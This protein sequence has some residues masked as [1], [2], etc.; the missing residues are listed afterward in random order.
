[1]S[2]DAFS[3]VAILVIGMAVGALVGWLAS[4]PA[5]ARLSGELE[6]ERASIAERAR[7]SEQA[8]AR[9]RETFQALSAEA[10]R[11][12]NHAFLDLAETR[13]REA[14]SEA[15]ADLDARKQA[16]ENLLTPLARTL[17]R[18]DHE[19]RESERRRVEAATTLVERITALDAV[20]Q[21]LRRETVR[22]VDALKRPG[23]RG[24]WGE[25][26]L[27][28]VVE[29]AGMLQ[30]CDFDAQTTV[31]SSDADRRMRPDVI[32]HLAGGKHL[33]ID[34]KAPLDAYLKALDAPDESSRQAWLA[35]HAQQ[36]RTHLLQLAAKGYAA[37]VHPS[38]DFV[39][40][41][42][43]GEM[44]FS[45]ALEQDAS[46]IE[47]G[48]EQRVIPASPTT[49]I[50]LLRAVAYG[51]QQEAME[52]NARKIG[53]LG[54][55]LYE[56]VRVLGGHFDSLGTKLKG[57]LDAYNLAVGSLERNVLVKAR[58]LKELHAANGGEE[59]MT[60]ESIDQVPRM[61]QAAELTGGLPF[62]DTELRDV[63]ENVETGDLKSEVEV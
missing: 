19:I 11:T 24:R 47:F 29:M 62:Q 57:A 35:D 55:N 26:Q 8:D 56:S 7:F 48:V 31:T 52:E 17:D 27:K 1:M 21:E 49:L 36:V 53:D 4:R 54:R 16:V 58:K 38:P 5:L 15:R 41:F 43:P 9:L 63:D 3:L 28:R 34:A 25:L 18:V 30:H 32:V 42:L 14:R 45:A 40:M 33:V 20:G 12:N 50:A 22:L 61:L 44:F 39:V 23:V 46:L 60:L 51:W 37:H 59:I 2:I 6:R 13:L 10:L